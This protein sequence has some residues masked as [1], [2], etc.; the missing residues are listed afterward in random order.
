MNASLIMSMQF[1]SSWGI[2]NCMKKPLKPRGKSGDTS[3]TIHKYSHAFAKDSNLGL[4]DDKRNYYHNRSILSP[5]SNVKKRL[6]RLTYLYYTK[7]KHVA[8][9]KFQNRHHWHIR[10][11]LLT[12]PGEC[13][14][15]IPTN[16]NRS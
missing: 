11:K 8:C 16:E 15:L 1:K 7:R 6:L 9:Y 3:G 12:L 10:Y 14:K 4:R 5:I 2:C 13:I